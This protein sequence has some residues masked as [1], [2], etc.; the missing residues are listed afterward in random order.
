MASLKKL[1]SQTAIYGLSSILGRLLNFVL[2]PLHTSALP[3]EEYGQ[4]T[5]IYSMIAFLMVILTFGMETA[6]FRFYSDKRFTHRQVFSATTGLT[7][8]LSIPF[9]LLVYAFLGPLADF[10]Q[11][12]Q[13]PEFVLWMAL[14]V[15]SE[16]MAAVPFAKLRAENRPVKFVVVRMA[17]TGSIVILN[18]LFFWLFPYLHREGMA[19][20]FIDLVYDPE[21]GVAYIFI[22]N[23]IGNGLLMLMF[24]PEFIR[25]QW[26]LNKVLFKEMVWYSTPLVIG[27]LAGI[28]NEMAN[29]QFLKYLLPPKENFEALGIFGANIKIATFMM[30]FIQAF[31]FAAEPFFFSGEGDFKD[32]MAKVMR[33]FVAIQAFIFVG[34]VCFL[35]I[36]K[37]T[38]FIDEKYWDGLSIVPILIFA[39]LLLGINFNL[40]IWYK[41]KSLTKMG[42]Y[43]TFM[44]LFFTIVS[45]F[46][47]VPY[48]GYMGAAWST[49][50][51]YASMTLYSYYLNQKYDRTDYPVKD[52]GLNLLVA[53]ILAG[54][55]FYIFK[56]QLFPSLLC[57]TA[58]LIFAWFAN[59]KT[60]LKAL[61][62]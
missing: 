38:R 56:S 61:R 30:L 12:A 7:C 50:I 39:N 34:L 25:I 37:Q 33:Y 20:G 41:I 62:K 40:N 60:L 26:S 54:I 29:R 57:F 47:L 24:L 43:I 17:T 1:A 58:Y 21:L 45:N 59:G 15:G 28:A 22:A 51:S 55:S 46:I 32:K 49:L 52:I 2:T 31:R 11:Y 18:V 16:A 53:V 42:V 27:G 13:H 23:L 6:F 3:K 10:L 8:M 4:N 19:S 14:I 36:I 48:Y 44:G 35:E 5:D 9:I